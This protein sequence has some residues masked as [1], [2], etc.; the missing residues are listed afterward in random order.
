MN[1]S[2]GDSGGAPRWWR[3]LPVL[4]LV[5]ATT[6]VPALVLGSKVLSADDLTRVWRRPGVLD[7]VWFSLWQ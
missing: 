5:S 4:L 6:V 7:A 3:D 1:R 2:R